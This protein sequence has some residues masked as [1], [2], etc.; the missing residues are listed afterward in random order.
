MTLKEALDTIAE[1]CRRTRCKDC[2]FHVPTRNAELHWCKLGSET[3]E[4]YDKIPIIE[5]NLYDEEEIHNNCTVQIL[6]NS[7]TG[8]T[9]I[10]W[11]K[12]GD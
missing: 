4:K 3:P 6:K 7:V 9:S 5:T 1:Y 10:G 11:W 8:E 12:D 2:P